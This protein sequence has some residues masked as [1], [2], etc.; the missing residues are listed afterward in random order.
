M[1]LIGLRL[2]RL[3]VSSLTTLNRFRLFTSGI[4]WRNQRHSYTFKSTR[5]HVLHSVQGCVS[6]TSLTSRS[7]P[8]NTCVTAFKPP[9]QRLPVTIQSTRQFHTSGGL[10]ALPAPVLWLVLKPIQK[11]VAIILGR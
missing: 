10:R 9:F 2:I 3:N 4:R 11:V 1:D 8:L 5:T 6:P 7:R